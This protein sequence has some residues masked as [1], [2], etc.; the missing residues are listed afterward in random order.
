MSDNTEYLHIPEE[1]LELF[2]HDLCDELISSGQ[3]SDEDEDLFTEEMPGY[4]RADL[5]L[6]RDGHYVCSIEE[7]Q[8]VWDELRARDGLRKLVANG[9]VDVLWCSEKNDFVFMPVDA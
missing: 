2:V 3:I 6:D 7:L 8:K 1:R 9:E 5:D 4:M